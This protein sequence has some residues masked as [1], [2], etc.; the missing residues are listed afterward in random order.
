[1]KTYL[2]CYPCFVNQALRCG[3][4]VTKDETIL[5]QLIDEVGM[6][7][8]DI[9]LTNTPPETGEIIFK[10][11]R[12]ISGKNDPLA[13][14]KNRSTQE[15]LEIYPQLK[16][17]VTSSAD[18]LMTAIR[19]AIAGNVIDFGISDDYD[20]GRE[21]QETVGKEFEICDIEPFRSALTR[22]QNILYIGD[23]AGESVFDRLLIE[24][25]GK[26]TVFIVREEPVLNDVIFDDAVA[27]GLD[28]VANI[29]SSGST[30]PG[31]ILE[32]CTR[33]FRELFGDA[34]LVIA[35]GQGNY[36]GLSTEKRPIYFL[37]KAKCPVIARDIGVNTGAIVLKR[38]GN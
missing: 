29:Y 21:I 9:P 8:K 22:A 35:K 34:D 18:P 6:M 3:R 4:W 33:E 19:L 7:L 30:A 24:T 17:M 13:E 14:V 28:K 31:T 38:N 25:M 16:Q 15:V 36:E 5:K 27:A 23:N 11:V 2:D 26:P 1:M 37:L 32:T 12:E 10:K 20:I